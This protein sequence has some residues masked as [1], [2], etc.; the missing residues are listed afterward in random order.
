[1]GVSRKL[2]IL[3][4]F[5]IVMICASATAEENAQ[6]L[7]SDNM[8]DMQAQIGDKV[9]TFE[10]T[11]ANLESQGVSFGEG[12]KP[13]KW[14]QVGIDG[15]SFYVLVDSFE[16]PRVHGYRLDPSITPDARI[17]KGLVI[18]NSTH[19]DVLQAYGLPDNDYTNS[20][21]YYFFDGYINLTFWFDGDSE[22]APIE[23]V[24]CVSDI[25]EFFGPEVSP[26]AGVKE[27]G[28]PDPQSLNLG[29][30]ILDGKLYQG[31][32]TVQDLLAKG[33]R[34]S[35]RD[36]DKEA[37]PTKHGVTNLT[38]VTLFNGKSFAGAFVYNAKSETE[39]CS[40]M[41][42]DVAGLRIYTGFNSD[43]V[44][45]KGVTLGS[46]LEEVIAVFGPDYTTDEVKSIQNKPGY[47]RYSF[48]R[49]RDYQCSVTFSISDDR[50]F[51]I[52][53]MTG[54]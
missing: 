36:V 12:A 35:A 50:V 52:R 43:I 15:L 45:A 49:N 24:E 30:F 44:L 8:L 2:A 21:E 27:E 14:N 53:M 9:L 22:D 54:I 38:Y 20:I 34:V 47:T 11:V 6:I 42:A 16:Q 31:R 37:Q 13:G 23:K 5:A 7:P 25:C 3:L 1:M 19:G 41:D 40:V 51:E 33:W 46:T 29:Q 39:T 18:G 10:D 17:P 48:D 32:Y 28:L 26:L 4:L